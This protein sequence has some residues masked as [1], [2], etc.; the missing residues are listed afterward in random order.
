[1]RIGTAMP[2]YTFWSTSQRYDADLK[3][4]IASTFTTIHHEVTGAPKYFVQ[5]I[6]VDLASDSIYVAGD[7]ADS[8]VWIRADIRSG[9]TAEQKRQLLERILDEVSLRLNVPPERIWVYICDVDGPAVA[10]YGRPLPNPGGEDE[11]FDALPPD[12]KAELRQRM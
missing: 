7:I 12:L 11:W 3:A 8:Q 5:V 4:S 2:T 10:E 9:R 6:F 1:M